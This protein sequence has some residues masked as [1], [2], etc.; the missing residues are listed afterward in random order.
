MEA[1]DAVGVDDVVVPEP[2]PAHVDGEEAA[3]PGEGGAGEGQEHDGEA[4]HRVE[5]VAAEIDLVEQRAA[6]PSG[7]EAGCGADAGLGDEDRHEVGPRGRG[8]G[9]E[10]DQ[11]DREEDRHRIVRSRLQLERGLDA[12]AQ[13]GAAP[14]QHGEDGGSVGRRHDRAEQ[15]ADLDR[16]VEQPRCGRSGDGSGDRHADRRQ[17]HPLAERGSDR[18]PAG[19]EPAVEEDEGQGAHPDGLRDRSVVE[20]DPAG[21]VGA[22]EHAEC[23]EEEERRDPQAGR[24][25]RR[26]HPCEGEDGPDEEDGFAEFRC[27]RRA[28]RGRGD[29]VAD[30]E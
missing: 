11:S 12:S 26:Q 6:T 24:E 3:A 23:E 28:G 8:T 17:R 27:S 30:S 9:G 19:R 18:P 7:G 22:G 14:P 16:E 10:L 2:Q 1:P 29:V 20:V 5:A 15:Q 4:Q 13:A 25:L 21:T